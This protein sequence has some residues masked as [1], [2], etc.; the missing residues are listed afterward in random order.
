MSACARAV[1]TLYNRRLLGDISAALN[2]EFSKASENYE[3]RKLRDSE[4]RRA[5]LMATR[6]TPGEDMEDR[7]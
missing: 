2:S 3:N 4:S 6:A 1:V 7:P 5:S